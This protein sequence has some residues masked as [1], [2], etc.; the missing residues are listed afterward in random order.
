MSLREL[1]KV[2]DSMMQANEKCYVICYA[3]KRLATIKCVRW[4]EYIEVHVLHAKRKMKHIEF[5]KGKTGAIV[6]EY[7]MRKMYGQ[8]LT[9]EQLKDYMVF[10]YNHEEWLNQKLKWMNIINEKKNRKF[11][12]KTDD[13]VEQEKWENETNRVL[14]KKATKYE[15]IVF[16]AIKDNIK[17]KISTQKK[18]KIA[19]HIYF[20]D[21]YFDNHKIAIEV[22]GGYHNSKKQSIKDKNRDINFELAHIKVF[23][24]SNQDVIDQCKLNDF[25]NSIKQYIKLKGK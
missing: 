13:E 18:I 10:E 19:N 5:V 22:D 12:N 3:R 23:R 1:I 7:I 8:D 2:V 20:A 6:P 11:L 25:I 24:I 15:S 4:Q 14:I 21:I 17:C 9:D 16:N